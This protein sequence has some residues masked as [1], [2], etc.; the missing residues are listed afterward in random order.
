[1][2]FWS[3]ILQED[4]IMNTAALKYMIEGSILQS[5]KVPSIPHVL[6]MFELRKGSQAFFMSVEP[7]DIHTEVYPADGL[8]EFKELI[9][10]QI[11]SFDIESGETV[12]EDDSLMGWNFYKFQGER[13]SATLRFNSYADQYYSI[14]VD[15]KCDK[16]ETDK[17]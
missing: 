12:M 8:D 5:V 4:K 13:D 16:I 10:Q 9:G 14:G 6:L 11:V 3:E 15:I 2:I 1:M 7:D 17:L